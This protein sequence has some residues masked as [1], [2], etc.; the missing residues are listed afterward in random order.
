MRMFGGGEAAV[1]T[2]QKTSVRRKGEI[3]R[4]KYL[5]SL[6]LDKQAE[7]D[8]PYQKI[9]AYPDHNGFTQAQ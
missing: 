2:L 9:L 7:E 5:V 4:M 8:V 3:A 1:L 6:R